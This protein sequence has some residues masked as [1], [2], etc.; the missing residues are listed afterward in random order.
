MIPKTVYVHFSKLLTLSDS[1]LLQHLL[2]NMIMSLLRKIK[3][4]SRVCTSIHHT[5]TAVELIYVEIMDWNRK[6][7]NIAG[8]AMYDIFYY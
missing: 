3:M 4:P 2:S 5:H 1:L 7:N 6:Q 8:D